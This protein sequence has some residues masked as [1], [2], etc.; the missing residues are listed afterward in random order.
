LQAPVLSLLKAV[1]ATYTV[2]TARPFQ[3]RNRHA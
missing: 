3:A 2:N 1:D